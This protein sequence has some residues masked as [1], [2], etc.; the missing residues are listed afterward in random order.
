[1]ITLLELFLPEAS[2]RSRPARSQ[3]RP[4]PAQRRLWQAE[5]YGSVLTDDQAGLDRGTAAARPAD[6]GSRASKGP[7]GDVSRAGAPESAPSS[8]TSA[9]TSRAA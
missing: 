8:A 2:R 1:M 9:T 4:T 6:R 5:L 7:V 3:G